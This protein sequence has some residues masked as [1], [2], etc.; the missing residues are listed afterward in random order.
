[1]EAIINYYDNYDETSRLTTD[2]VGKLEYIT[3]THVLDK[4]INNAAEVLDLGAGTG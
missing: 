4:Y 1:M 2:N 3:T